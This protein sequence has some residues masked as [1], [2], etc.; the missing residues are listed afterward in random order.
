MK[1]NYSSLGQLN[2]LLMWRFV[3][4]QLIVI[5]V[6]FSACMRFCMPDAMRPEIISVMYSNIPENATQNSIQSDKI[7][8]FLRQIKQMNCKSPAQ[9]MYILYMVLHRT[10]W[11][12]STWIIHC[13]LVFGLSFFSVCC[14]LHAQLWPNLMLCIRVVFNY[15]S[16]RIANGIDI[17]NSP[18]KFGIET[19]EGHEIVFFFFTNFFKALTVP[20]PFSVH[21]YDWFD[22][23][24]VNGLFFCLSDRNETHLENEW[25]VNFSIYILTAQEVLIYIYVVQI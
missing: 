20:Y 17:K 15:F 13:A 19:P 21:D 7:K 2:D 10:R 18:Q 24:F 6:A 14:W 3:I 11:I 5:C 25:S 12:R 8:C 16:P 23:V 1:N 4:T 9:N 22:G